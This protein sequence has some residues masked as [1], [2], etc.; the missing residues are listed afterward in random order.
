MNCLLFQ[1]VGG[2]LGEP[3]SLKRVGRL[4]V[5]ADNFHLCWVIIIKFAVAEL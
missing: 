5:C 1:G 3:S 4:G 2:W